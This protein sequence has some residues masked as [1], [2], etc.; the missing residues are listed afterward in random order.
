MPLLVFLRISNTN[1]HHLPAWFVRLKSLQSI[2]A[3]G[4]PCFIKDPQRD[5]PVSHH[6][7]TLVDISAARILEFIANGGD[8]TQASELPDHLVEKV[9]CSRPTRHSKLQLMRNNYAG[10]KMF[11]FHGVLM[12]D[13]MNSRWQLLKTR[14][15]QLEK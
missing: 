4:S 9:M 2:E 1:I 13:L 15:R 10:V 14:K 11:A 5:R 8:W 7:P 6:H 12:S 3:N